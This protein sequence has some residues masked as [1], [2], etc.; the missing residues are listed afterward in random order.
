MKF[1]FTSFTSRRCGLKNMIWLPFNYLV[2]LH[3]Y[4]QKIKKNIVDTL[5]K[6]VNIS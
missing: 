4:K 3:F 1:S 5:L 6:C 2:Y